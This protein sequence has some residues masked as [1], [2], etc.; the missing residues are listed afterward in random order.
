V[1]LAR[2]SIDQMSEH[3]AFLL[4]FEIRAGC[5]GSNEKLREI[6]A[7]NTQGLAFRLFLC[8]YGWSIV[9][10]ITDFDARVKCAALIVNKAIML[11]VTLLTGAELRNLCNIWL[12][13]HVGDD[14]VCM[15]GPSGFNGDLQNCTLGGHIEKIALVMDFQNVGLLIAERR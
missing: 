6:S 2:I 1:K 10:T 4:A 7:L 5:R 14:I 15:V 3:L 12:F 8:G 11:S 9:K 13:A